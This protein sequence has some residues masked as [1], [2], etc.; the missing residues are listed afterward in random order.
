[1]F[2]LLSLEA[3]ARAVVSWQVCLCLLAVAAQYYL[4]SHFQL[5]RPPCLALA[6]CSSV[7][8]FFLYVV[9]GSGASEASS[10]IS[11]EQQ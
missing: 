4:G 6:W 10:R 5:E 8:G 11:N 9:N 1:M 7:E 3:F 2:T